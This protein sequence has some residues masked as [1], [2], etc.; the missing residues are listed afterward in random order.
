MEVVYERCCGLDVP[1]DMVVACLSIIE[2]GQRR[3][4]IRTFRTV[5]KEL[6][7]MRQWLLSEG[8]SHVGMESTGVLGRP[9]YD[10]LAGYF[11]LVL[12][13]AAH[14]KQVPGRKTDMQDADW[15]AD[16]L[17]HGLLTSSCVPDQPQQ[18]L[19]DLTRLRVHLVQ[20]RAQL[21]NR[22]LNVLQQ[23]GIKLSG[24]LSDVVGVSGRAILQALC[25]GE[26]DPEQLASLVHKSVAHKHAQLV[27]ALTGGS[28]L[29]S[30][31]SLVRAALFT[32]GSGAIHQAG[33]ARDRAAAA[34]RGGEACAHGKDH[35]SQSAHLT[36]V[37]RG[38]GT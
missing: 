33:G 20:D 16:L 6:L 32:L 2:A 19:R 21:I 4:E 17:Q 8:C 18:D 11:E 24:V 10:R 3:K 14:M 35:G 13:N 22:I 37:V 29:A 27:E 30:S 34:P 23:G 7:A 1:R 26:R 36:S 5:T 25:V 15:L 38:S 28:A 31:V 12:V 9:V